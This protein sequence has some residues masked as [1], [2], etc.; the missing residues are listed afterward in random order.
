MISPQAAVSANGMV[1]FMD[2]G[3]FYVYAGSVQSLPC[4]VKDFVFSGLNLQQSYKVFAAANPDF[5]EVTWFYPVGTENTEV[6]RY[7]TYNYADK[8]WTVGTFDRTAWIDAPSRRFPIA[9]GVNGDDNNY[10]YEQEVGNSADGSAIEAFIESGDIDL[11]DGDRF[12]FMRRMI[13]DFTFRGDGTPSV[14]VVVKGRNYPMKDATVRSTSTI[15]S[16][17]GEVYVSNRMRQA[18]IRIESNT[19]NFYWRMGSLRADMRPD[20][21]R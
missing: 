15:S 11:D 13:P 3:D 12:V 1:F 18:I 2:R 8:A 14:D 9:A 20:G 16:N 7:V 6:S 4:T 17:S 19:D 10:L 5:N 21:R